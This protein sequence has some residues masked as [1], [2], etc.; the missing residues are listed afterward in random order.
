MIKKSLYSYYKFHKILIFEKLPVLFI[1]LDRR[2]IILP[3]QNPKLV[4]SL[5]AVN[6][7]L[8]EPDMDSSNS[9]STTLNS[10]ASGTFVGR[11][12]KKSKNNLRLADSLEGKKNKLKK[13]KIR[14]KIHLD[15]EEEAFSDNAISSGVNN[16]ALALSLMRP[17][18]PAK[19]KRSIRVKKEKSETKKKKQSSDLKLTDPIIEDTSKETF[20]HNPLTIQDLSTQ[21]S[22]PEAEIITWLFLQG[23]SVTMNQV[24][25][26]SIASSVAEHYGFIVQSH[27]DDASLKVYSHSKSI[28]LSNSYKGEKRPP[29]ITI[30]GHVDHGKTTL[31]DAIRTT[32]LVNKEVGGITQS[33]GAYEVQLEYKFNC[34]KLVFLDTP[35]HEAFISMRSRGAQVTDLAILVVAADDSLK[36]QTIEAINHIQNRRLPFVVAIN[37]ID[38]D[39]ADPSK[40]KEQLSKYNIIGEDWGGDVPIVELSA[41]NSTNI[42]LLLSTLFLLSDLQDLTA[43]PAQ[44]AR[45]TILEAHLDKQTGPIASII[46]QDGTLSVGD[47]IVSGNLYGKVKALIDS[48]E[49]K[50]KSAKP[51]SIVKVWGFS[52]VPDAGLEFLVVNDE[53]EAKRLIDIDN[54]MNQV[55]N[56]QQ[57]LNSRVTLDSYR[58]KRAVK[59]VNIILKTDTQGSIEAII[60]SFAQI[61]QEK[62]QLNILS[63]SSGQVSDQDIA[64]ASMS[65]S[66]ILGFNL[67]I[68]LPIQHTADK[69]NVLILKFNIIYDLLDHIKNYMLN[70]VEPEYL[71]VDIGEAIVE[72]VFSINKGSVAGCSVS[73]GKLK[74]GAYIDVYRGKDLVH[75]GRLDSLKKIKDDVEEVSYGNE[76]GVM[77]SEYNLWQKLDIIKAYELDPKEKAL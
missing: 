39:G 22:I 18:K 13:K 77:C 11:S 76:C 19:Q 29:I 55:S 15:E 44:L 37:K 27:S 51:S 7:V 48:S 36:P 35:G 47:I 72:A 30:F 5:E 32:N 49:S 61:P 57:L 71:Q 46:V 4:Y 9:F 59:Q 25:D 74:R 63:T 42:D 62:V 33:I 75:N 73:S 54:S 68:S 17:I 43:D 67:N 26:I 21:L 8:T 60:N 34:E 69:A 3:L 24:V 52:A 53:K 28:Y 6:K 58:Q 45:G 10:D 66:V 14:T 38:K 2:E 1:S 65:Q 56:I 12:D 23:I 40:I 64:L 16:D 20:F 41:L 50:L 70:L 31:L